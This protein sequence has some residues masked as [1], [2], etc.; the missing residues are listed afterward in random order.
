MKIIKKEYHTVISEFTF[1]L[2]EN[3]LIKEFG[4]VEEFT[5][6]LNDDD[7]D[8]IEF[9]SNYDYERYDDWVSDRKGGYDVTYEVKND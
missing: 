8:A 1:E 5:N 9:L 2:S 4:S 6:A 7:F 3:D